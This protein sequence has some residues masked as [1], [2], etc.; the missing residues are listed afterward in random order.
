MKESIKNIFKKGA[1]VGSGVAVGMGA[2]A[3]E[4]KTAEQIF[5]GDEKKVEATV[6]MDESNPSDKPENANFIKE[7]NNF[8]LDVKEVVYDG[9]MTEEEM[10]KE[11]TP[12]SEKEALEIASQFKKD[13]KEGL[14]W[15][16][17]QNGNICQMLVW[18]D[19]NNWYTNLDK[20][21]SNKKWFVGYHSF[22]R[23]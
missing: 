15:F 9:I 12:F 21:K 10:V 6:N 7:F 4:H 17:N 20:S 13:K 3:Q 19:G 22:F 11:H 1:M 18:F 8:N 23:N 5:S 14:I 16:I 2:N